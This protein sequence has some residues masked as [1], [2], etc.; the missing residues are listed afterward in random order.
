MVNT[1]C[2][3]GKGILFLWL[4]VV[5]YAGLIFYLSSL[6]PTQPLPFSFSG[7]DKVIHFFMYLGFSFLLLR[8]LHP[9]E[10]ISPR[11]RCLAAF[12]LAAGYG[13]SDEFHQYFVPGRDCSGFDLLA[14]IAG[15]AA[16]ILV[17]ERV[18]RFLRVSA[19]PD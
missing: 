6:T 7:S 17:F 18:T 9:G 5:L 1:K 10:W 8:A 12:L 2:K 3:G 15:A 4:P 14:D 19:V 16:G 11:N 13:I